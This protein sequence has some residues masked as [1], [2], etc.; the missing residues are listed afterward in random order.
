MKNKLRSTFIFGAKSGPEKY[1]Q[2]T[3]RTEFFRAPKAEKK[4]AIKIFY[5]KLSM[6][7][8][9]NNK[10]FVASLS[11]FRSE[12]FS[13]IHN[14]II[15]FHSE[16]IHV[17]WS[18][19]GEIFIRIILLPGKTT[20]KKSGILFFSCIIVTMPSSMLSAPVNCSWWRTSIIKFLTYLFYLTSFTSI[21]WV[22][23]LLISCFFYLVFHLA[24]AYH[25]FF[26]LLLISFFVTLHASSEFNVFVNEKK[27]S[28]LAL[29]VEIHTHSHL[30]QQSSFIFASCQNTVY[31]QRK[32]HD[33]LNDFLF[34]RE[35]CAS[36]ARHQI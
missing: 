5:F 12:T 7:I 34:E 9:F 4:T 27:E 32:K 29:T 22:F 26:P 15:S 28:K 36:K 8:M 33:I 10:S 6:F 30:K 14:S 2:H 24:L 18:R 35:M 25:F 20:T 11:Q 23:I 17:S 1:F 3:D 19:S 16:C 31:R 21:L 13:E